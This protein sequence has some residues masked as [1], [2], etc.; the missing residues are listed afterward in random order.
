MKK[1][2]YIK[3]AFIVTIGIFLTK[4][5]GMLYV[6][7]FY[8]IIGE[9]GGALYG[10]A[11]NIYCTFLSISSA[12]IPMAIS[13]IISEYNSL[14]YIDDK[15]RA[16]RIGKQLALVLGV[17]AFI[18]LFVFAPDIAKLIMGNIEGGNSPEDISLVIRVISSAIIVVPVLSV[19][20][21]YFEGH[22]FFVPTSISQI[23]EQLVRV[24]II[25]VGSYITL[26]VLD[27]SLT[28]SVGV[29]VFGATV[30]AFV[31]YLYLE[32]KYLKKK[33]LFENTSD[34]NR[35]YSDLE[36]LKKILLYALPLIMIEIFKTLYNSVDVI[37][38]VRTLVNK[39]NYDVVEAESVMSVL[40]TWGSKLNMIITSISTGMII[41]LV[42]SLTSSIVSDDKK[43]IQDIVDQT[44]LILLFFVVPMTVGLSF[45]SKPIWMIFYGSSELGATTFSYSIFIALFF[46]IFASTI[47]ITQ[48]LKSYK[49]VFISLLF[50][51]LLKAFLNIPLIVVF[52]MFGL[53]AHYGAITASILGYVLSFIICFICLKKDYQISFRLVIKQ[54]IRV[55]VATLSMFLVLLVLKKIVPYFSCRRIFNI[56]I[57]VVYAVVGLIVYLFTSW[58]LG[59]IKEIFGITGIN[60]LLRKLKLSFRVKEK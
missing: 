12:G 10:Y 58:K 31:S 19:Y 33:T 28:T 15:Q 47:T 8:Q 20:R 29:A 9:Q 32:N 55:L 2:N 39:A 52:S 22:K 27:L 45:L 43:E 60:K 46:C 14:G 16:F 59:L 13:K 41:S 5:I 23:V 1:N 40:S 25:L 21:G 42:P 53:T 49:M 7:P 35:H 4:I 51:F 34:R 36:I 6:V 17:I 56:P 44:F 18:I 24:F 38:L 30:G 11:Y 57:I 50:G 26:K 3:G 48:V 54:A 37:T